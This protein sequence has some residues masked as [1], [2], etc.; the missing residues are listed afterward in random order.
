MSKS[1]SRQRE[2]L[3]SQFKKYVLSSKKE[4]KIGVF[5]PIQFAEKLL[6]IFSLYNEIKKK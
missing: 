1:L 6:H 5:L 4:K 2:E 3:L